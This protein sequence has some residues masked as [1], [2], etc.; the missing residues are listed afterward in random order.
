MKILVAI[1]D[2]PCSQEVL[3]YIG[4]MPWTESDQF[5]VL[6]VVEP[7]PVDV[8][9]GVA[10]ESDEAV[11]QATYDACA[12]LTARACIAIRDRLPSN[13]V[14]AKVL[15]GHPSEQIVDFAE[16]IEADL[17]IMGSHGRRGFKKFL[18]GSVADEVLKRATCS[19][20]VIKARA[21]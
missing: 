10:P 1:D 3:R 17:V 9:L 4:E 13:H 8:G 14:E 16:S 12:D 5:I 15:T 19:V 21:A 20:G 6:S 2:S 7:I 18:L 11:D